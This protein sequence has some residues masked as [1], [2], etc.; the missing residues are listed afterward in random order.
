MVPKPQANARIAAIVA[1]SRVRLRTPAAM[2]TGCDPFCTPPAPPAPARRDRGHRLATL[3]IAAGLA[4]PGVALASDAPDTKSSR[5]SRDSAESKLAKES[6]EAK[7]AAGAKEAQEAAQLQSLGAKIADSLSRSRDARSSPTNGLVIRVKAPEPPAASAA[8][9]PRAPSAASH[10]T[11]RGSAASPPPATS[12]EAGAHGHGP[13]IHWGYSGDG[14]P[15]NWWRLKP[16]FARCAE[17]ARQSPINIRG[18]I[19]L[20]LE[21]IRFEYRAS[22]FSVIDNGHTVQ[23]TTSPGNT[24]SVMGRRYELIQFHFHRPA[25]ERV[26]GRVFDMV[27]HLVHRDPDGRLAVVAVL[28][29]RGQPNPVIQSVWNSLPLERNEALAGTAPIE[30]EQLLPVNRGYYTYMGSLTTPPCSEGVLWLVMKEPVTLS[31]E[32][33]AIFSRLYP[34]NA[35]PLQPIGDRLVKESK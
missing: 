3:L 22:A 15:E 20:D 23:V 35:R 13:S 9:K 32:Q 8:P 7:A 19:Q 1:A 17:G 4:I 30:L 27:A 14:G 6:R 18:G 12:R 28:L 2:T 24:L 29:D 10:G 11:V 5:S 16:E 34:M 25:E 31:T 21:P 33:I 26:D